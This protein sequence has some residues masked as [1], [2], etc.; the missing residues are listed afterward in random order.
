MSNF[1]LMFRWFLKHGGW[2]PAGAFERLNEA[3]QDG[4]LTVEEYR[5][6]LDTPM[7]GG[8]KINA[9]GGEA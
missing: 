1:A 4:K 5:E 9:P 6:L 7:G 8:A 2:T 3:F